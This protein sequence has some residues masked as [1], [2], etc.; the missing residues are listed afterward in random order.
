[1]LC[2]SSGPGPRHRLTGAD[3]TRAQ[4]SCLLVFQKFFQLVVK[5]PLNKL[6]W[7]I[8]TYFYY[9]VNHCTIIFLKGTRTHHFLIILFLLVSL[10]WRWCLL[11]GSPNVWKGQMVFYALPATRRI[12]PL[13]HCLRCDPGMRYL[14]AD[15]PYNGWHL[16]PTSVQWCASGAWK[17]PWGEYFHRRSQMLFQSADS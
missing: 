3:P 4:E 5:Q 11:Q 14:Q 17:L 7:Y 16:F 9:V 10:F 1:M 6:K 2:F 12:W 15:I 13:S 8:H